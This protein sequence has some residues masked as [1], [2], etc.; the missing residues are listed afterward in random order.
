M[1]TPKFSSSSCH[2]GDGASPEFYSTENYTSV[3]AALKPFADDDL[4]H[5]PGSKFLYTTYGYTLLSAVIEESSGKSFQ[6]LVTDLTRLVGMPSTTFDENVTIIANRSRYYQRNCQNKLLNAPSV[7]NSNK[8]AG[9]G[10]VST[11]GDLVKFGN[12]LITAHQMKNAEN[13]GVVSP[14]V[15]EEMWAGE[16][17]AIYN[18][19]RVERYGLGFVVIPKNRLE[20]VEGCERPLEVISHTGGA[21][22]A[23]S[24]LLI[25]PEAEAKSGEGAKGICVAI[26]CN[27]QSVGLTATARKIAR[28]FDGVVVE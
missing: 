8:W 20:K 22:G 12:A 9:G 26:L 24:V 14:Q 15:L 5:K 28:E 19:E 4:V 16:A 11:V 10:L 25:I 23:S 3:S 13:K 17:N 18:K 21:V 27:L 2:S 6:K 1:F 7:N